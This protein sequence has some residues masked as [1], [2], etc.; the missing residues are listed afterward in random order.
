MK[1]SI[2]DFLGF[3]CQ[4]VK[5]QRST[6]ITSSDWPTKRNELNR[7]VTDSHSQSESAEDHWDCPLLSFLLNLILS[8]LIMDW[9]VLSF[10]FP[11]LRDQPKNQWCFNSLGSTRGFD[12]WLEI[13][14]SEEVNK[15]SPQQRGLEG[16]GKRKRR[17]KAGRG[18]KGGK[19]RRKWG[20]VRW[21][22]W[23]S[24]PKRKW[25]RNKIS[26]TEGNR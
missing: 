24:H 19:K 5:M 26:K 6:K 21:N 22:V 11:S 9:H 20:N 17:R 14:R 4:K 10:P 2:W 25:N 8:S 7:C 18:R 13:L 1:F 15:Y 23:G 16:K 3:E 12:D